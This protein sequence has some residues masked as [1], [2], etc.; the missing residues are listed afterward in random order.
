MDENKHKYSPSMTGAATSF[1]FNGESVASS[2]RESL[3]KWGLVQHC[4]L[5]HKNMLHH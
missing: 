4:V 5:A 1:T 3:R 2:A